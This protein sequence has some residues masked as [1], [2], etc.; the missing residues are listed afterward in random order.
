MKF[1]F[2]L[3]SGQWFQVLENAGLV[4]AGAIIT[5]LTANVG[6]I[7][8]GTYSPLIVA[9]LTIGLNYLNNLVKNI[10]PKT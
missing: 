8:F 9:S 4:G 2:N 6:N 7:N 10:Q 3:P 1:S 5:A